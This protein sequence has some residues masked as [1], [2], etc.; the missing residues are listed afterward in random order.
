[1]QFDDEFNGAGLNTSNWQPNWL[2]N[3]DATIT[4]PINGSELSCYDPA[5]VSQPGDGYLH[6]SAVARSCRAS[7]GVTYSYASGLVESKP[8]FTFTYGYMEARMYLP[9]NGG[10]TAN[11]PA[12][13]TD[14]TGTWPTT[15][16]LDVFEGLHG[17]DCWHFHSPSGGPGGCASLGDPTGWHTFGARWEPGKVTFY[18]DGN[19][20]GVIT[21]GITGA[22]MY[23]ILNLGI[24]GEGGA[25]V[26]PSTVLVDYVRISK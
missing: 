23:P 14:G 12:F 22:P 3:N 8:H 19:Q 1:M 20:V 10:R 5:Q 6:L 18:Y 7:D 17:N 11:W 9:A 16:E 4:K 15:G 26:V 25:V 21:S 24:G 2:G 13:W